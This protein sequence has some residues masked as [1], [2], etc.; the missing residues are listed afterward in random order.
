MIVPDQELPRTSRFRRLLTDPELAFVMEAHDGI[1]ARIAEE[2]G[3]R[4]VWASGLSISATM[5][6]RDANEASWTQVLDHVEFMADATDVPIMV[7]AD[8]GYGNFNNVRRLVRKLEER[9]VAA[10]CIE[11][12]LFP[13]AN[14]YIRGEDQPL[15]DVAEFQGK[16]RAAKDTQR[17]PDFTVVARC[18]ALIAGLGMG[19]A[20]YR[21]E[22]YREAGADA[23]LVHSK[24]TTADEVVEFMSQW[25]GACPIVIVPT[26][27]YAT[28]PEVF[29]RAG[30]AAVIWGNQ[31]LRA[32]VAAMQRLAGEL[33]RA[34]SLAGLEDGIATVKEIFRLTDAPELDEAEVRYLPAASR[35]RL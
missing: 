35:T 2:A 30:I 3:F 19:E 24:Q 20:L 17:D 11:D 4:A 9:G 7:D 1:S 28:P 15:V 18:E 21:A 16:L 29:E 34:R 25:S 13:K 33:V 23:V 5:G 32:S 10:M 26:T 22:A 12:K 27:Y 8:T 31:L 6:V 14:S